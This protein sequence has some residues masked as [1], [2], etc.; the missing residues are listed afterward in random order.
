MSIASILNAAGVI[1]LTAISQMTEITETTLNN[2]KPALVDVY[3]EHCGYSVQMAQVYAG[4]VNNNPNI[5]FYGADASVM[6]GLS[7]QYNITGV[8]SFIGF[9]CGKEFGRVTGADQEGLSN[10]INNIGSVT[11]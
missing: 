1:A 11:C 3:S 6:A 4:F 2:N 8:P 10:L 9:A 7:D 5:Q